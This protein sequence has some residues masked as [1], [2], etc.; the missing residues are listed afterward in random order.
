MIDM[1]VKRP[2]TASAEVD[3]SQVRGWHD[4]PIM[5]P[6]QDKF[7]RAPVARRLA[8]LIHEGHSIE[9]STVYGLEGPW[10]CG[11]SSVISMITA[12]LSCDQYGWRI[13]NFTPWA[14]TGKEGLLSEFFAALSSAAP[15]TSKKRRLWKKFD[16]YMS[17]V[18]PFTPLIP[19]AGSAIYAGIK[20]FDNRPRKPWKQL[21]D[22]LSG[23]FHKLGSPVL[24]VVDDIDRLQAEELLDLLKVVRLIGRF[25]G[26]DFLLAYDE[27]TL[28]DILQS[29]CRGR[30]PRARA[31][32]FMEKIVQYPLA[33]PP[34]LSGQISKTVTDS[35]TEMLSSR[36]GQFFD[37]HRFSDVI[38]DIMPSRLTTPRAIARFLAQVREELTIHDPHEIDDADLILATFLRTQFPD[39]FSQLQDWKS[40]LTANVDSSIDAFFNQQDEKIDWSPLLQPL[41]N[42][43][44]RHNAL[45]LLEAIFPA[46]GGQG[47][48]RSG[49]RRFANPEYFDRYLAQAIPEW[50]VPDKVVRNAL[51][52][53]AEGNPAELQNLLRDT[54]EGHLNLVLNKIIA[55]YPDVNK[56]KYHDG[57]VGPLSRNLLATSMEL[58]M[59]RR[60]I[61]GHIVTP[62]DA[63][64]QWATVLLHLLLEK[65]PEANLDQELAACQFPDKRAHVVAS[66]ARRTEGLSPEAAS[67]LKNTFEREVQRLV[68]V[69]LNNLRERD[70][71][72][73]DIKMGSLLS[74]VSSSSAGNDL[75]AG[76]RRGLEI[77]EFTLQDIAARLVGFGYAIGGSGK[78]SGGSFDGQLFYT[79]TGVSARSV[80]HDYSVEWPDDSW[81]RRREYAA[82]L[83]EET[84]TSRDEANTVRETTEP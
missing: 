42:E 9:S 62:Y 44:D 28:V 16:N 80:D 4:D 45:T 1:T 46:V 21:F 23:E 36:V 12:T 58:L 83:I 72:N 22:D 27:Q 3:R 67:S 11:K 60:D 2:S 57:P 64:R 5:T 71:A 19:V 68:P 15:E 61:P 55:L 48:L 82:P 24:V 35:L 49:S 25:S 74:L 75:I 30:L 56:R 6:E 26:V 7:G 39:V 79:L 81:A 33:L 34:L 78:P 37:I 69:L 47:G 51:N 77:Q 54:D 20:S 13:A 65:N 52:D 59:S 41:E 53:A 38:L 43:K 8:N 14:T 73:T 18:R 10:G 50:D 70:A 40:K 29:P 31:R 84:V 17:V 32:A 66:A 63:L 76:I